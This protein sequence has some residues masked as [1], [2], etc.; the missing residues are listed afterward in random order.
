MKVVQFTIDEHLL[1]QLDR[2]PDVK[3]HGRS[4]LLRRAIKE[5]LARRGDEKIAEGYRRAYGKNP[6]TR[7]EVEAFDTG[8]A[9]PEE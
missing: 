1:R 7:D 9:W 4:A 6:L 8:A 5:F 2:D 3:K